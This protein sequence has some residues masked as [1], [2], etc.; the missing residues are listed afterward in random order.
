MMYLHTFLSLNWNL[1]FKNKPKRTCTYTPIHRD[2]ENDSSKALKPF[3]SSKEAARALRC[4][5]AVVRWG[6]RAPHL[7][8]DQA[9]K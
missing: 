5:Q 3:P 9:G 2:T 7:R 1:D 6:R 4:G 8:G